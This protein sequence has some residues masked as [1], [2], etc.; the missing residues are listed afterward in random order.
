M[1]CRWRCTAEYCIDAIFRTMPHAIMPSISCYSQWFFVLLQ[2]IDQLP[3]IL[4]PVQ[5]NDW[6][7]FTLEMFTKHTIASHAVSEDDN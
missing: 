2:F 7:Q 3:L 5:Q 1:Q 4:L 6:K